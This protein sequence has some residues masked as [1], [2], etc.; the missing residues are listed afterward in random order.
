MLLKEILIKFLVLKPFLGKWMK[1]REK[2]TV[3]TCV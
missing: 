3:Y 1:N 2:T